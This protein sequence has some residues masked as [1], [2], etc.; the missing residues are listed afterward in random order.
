MSSKQFLSSNNLVPYFSMKNDV[1]SIVL[2]TLKN[3]PSIAIKY[4]EL[5]AI[6]RSRNFY[7]RI[8]QILKKTCYRQIYRAEHKHFLTLT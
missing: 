1:I 5:S 6:Q 3:L 8:V 7:K 4:Q 2:Y